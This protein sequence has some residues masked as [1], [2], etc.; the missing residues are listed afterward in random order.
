M[1]DIVKQQA[2][3]RNKRLDPLS[4]PVET[5]GQSCHF[6]LALDLDAGVQA[7]ESGGEPVGGAVRDAQR[8]TEVVGPHQSE[9]RSEKLGPVRPSPLLDAELDSR[10]PD[11]PWWNSPLGETLAALGDAVEEGIV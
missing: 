4:R 5:V 10:R 6:I 1:G 3:L 8:M 11:S 9:H 2:V 7:V